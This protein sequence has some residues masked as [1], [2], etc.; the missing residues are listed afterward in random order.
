LKEA[1]E[2]RSDEAMI[3]EQA[4]NDLHE[5]LIKHCGLQRH[6]TAKTLIALSM[7]SVF[8]MGVNNGD[9]E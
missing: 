7:G 1:R 9:I 6:S 5:S 8:L 3:L 2:G 4:V